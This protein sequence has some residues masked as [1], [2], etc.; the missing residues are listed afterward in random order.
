ML[1]FKSKERKKLSKQL[2]SKKELLRKNS[3][4]ECFNY[5]NVKVLLTP[6]NVFR[7]INF[8]YVE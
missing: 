3:S 6:K 7:L 2:A 4:L 5:Y 1:Q 8:M